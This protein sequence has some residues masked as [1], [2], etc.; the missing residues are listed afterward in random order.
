MSEDVLQHLLYLLWF[1]EDMTCEQ[2]LQN[3]EN[4]F[5]HDAMYDIGRHIGAINS[6]KLHH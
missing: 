4:T 1:G 3:I 6:K 2:A 5:G